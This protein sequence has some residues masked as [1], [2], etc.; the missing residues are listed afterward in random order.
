MKPIV[1]VF[2]DWE[3]YKGCSVLYEEVGVELS[4]G[5]FHPG[6]TFSGKIELD[7]DGAAELQAALEAGFRPVFYLVP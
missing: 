3:D 6:A 7:K 1:M 4:L 2:E 5:D